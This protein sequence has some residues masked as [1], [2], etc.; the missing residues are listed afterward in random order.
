M[1]GAADSNITKK[2][3]RGERKT[4]TDMLDC[5]LLALALFVAQAYHG[6]TVLGLDNGAALTPPMGWSTWNK[7]RCDFT[8]ERLLQE[9]DYMVSS[10]MLTAGYKTLNIDDCWMKKESGRNAAGEII[11]DPEKFP[12]GM[13]NF[14]DELAKRGVGLGIYTAHGKLTCQKYPAS[15]GY[16]DID[17]RTY[18]SWNV[19][20]VKNDWCWHNE[21]NATKHLDAF[22]AMRDAL[23]KTG[24]SIVHSIHWNY[25]DVAGPGC[26]QN[27]D[28][29]LPDTANMWR[30]GGDIRPDFES[31]VLRL[32]DIDTPHASQAHPGAWG[33][34]DVR[35]FTLLYR[36]CIERVSTMYLSV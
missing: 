20:Y 3:C 33:D 7:L 8:A 30:I 32:I 31:G 11:P 35:T 4:T 15:L 14:S 28:C 19:V 6:A 17:A 34:A 25:E 10:G 12:Y 1:Q 5:K 23:N 13:K 26:A 2:I 16:E 24:Q 36:S 27:I 21:P 22:N 18:A 9:A 29:P